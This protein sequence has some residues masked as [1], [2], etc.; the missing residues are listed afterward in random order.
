MEKMV[1]KYHLDEAN[2]D[3]EVKIVGEDLIMVVPGQPDYKL[4]RTAPRTFKPAGAPD[5]FAVK[6]TPATDDATEL[7]LTQPN[8]VSTLKRVASDAGAPGGAGAMSSGPRPT[9]R[10]RTA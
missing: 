9:R 1:G 6:F 3:I 7:I 5:G 8:R 10:P 4:E 2:I